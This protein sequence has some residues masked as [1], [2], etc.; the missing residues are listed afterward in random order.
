[1]RKNFFILIFLFFIFSILNANPLKNET[2]LQKF[3]NKVDKVIKEELK[4]DYK[5]EYLKRKDNL[6][7]IENNGEIGF[8][9]ED[10]IFQFE[11]NALTLASK[12]LKSIPNTAITQEFD[13][14]GNFFRIFSITSIDENFLLYRY[15]DKNS[16]LVIDVYGTNGKVIQ[17]GY[18]NNKQL[19]YIIEGNILKNLDSIPNGKY[20]EYY[21]N[22]QIKI[23]GHTKEGKRDGEFKA[24][25]KNGKSAGSV[26]YK[27]G[28]IIK[29]TLIN[30]M[31]DNA[32]FPLIDNIN[33]K[34]DT[35]HT[36]GKVEFE[37]GLLRTY[38]IFNKN[39]LLDGNSI[40]YYEEGNIES[41]VP[42]KNNVV[43]GL[44]ITY[45]EN[46]NIKEEV[47]YKNDKMNGEAK[48]YDE[49]GKLNGRTIF[50]D[51]IKLEEDVHK[52]NE[53]LKNTFKNGELVKQDICSPNGTLKE[54]RILNGDEMEYSTFYPNGNVKQKIFAK[55]KIIIKEQLY[56]RNGNIMSNSFFSNGKPVTEVFEYYPDGKIHKKISSS[57]NMLDGNYLEYYPNGKLKNKAFFK[58][59]KQ[60]G[61]YTAYYE[62]SAIMQKVPYK[63]GIRNGE[64]IAYYENGNI[65]QKAYFING[66]QE[67][68]H[69]YYDKKGNLIKTE[70]YKNGVKQ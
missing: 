3:R 66:K 9:D 54:R 68:E 20:I 17:K 22:G 21:K 24:F 39:G 48:S 27:D 18:Y 23:Q 28:K 55:D 50:K 56:A 33:Y 62:S 49:N 12:K 60:E 61:E 63:N 30:S 14:T 67:K 34:L 36:L 26:I 43:E 31:K 69:L 58:N 59:D 11:D 7:K 53:I 13:K 29:S 46:G 65:E 42:Y 41:L 38:F 47:N 4:N 15:F 52:K 5:K 1:M 19:A 44:V 64:A 25:L 51:D 57:N 8:E 40:E 2:E 6:K 10:F 32:S 37:N 16:N 35:T 45:Y 70:I